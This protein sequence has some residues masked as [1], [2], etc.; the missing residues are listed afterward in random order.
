MVT[1]I[2]LAAYLWDSSD[3]IDSCDSC[4]SCD[5]SDS[6]DSSEEEKK[7]GIINLVHTKF[8]PK[9]LEANGF[10]HFLIV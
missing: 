1:K 7:S 3:S 9:N 5:S 8:T 2:Y 6:S 4:D 10:W